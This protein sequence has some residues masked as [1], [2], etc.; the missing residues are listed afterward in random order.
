MA[1]VPPAAGTPVKG[2]EVTYVWFGDFVTQVLGRSITTGRAG[3]VAIA[4]KKIGMN[5]QS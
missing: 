1:R 5:S 4:G 3:D 2:W